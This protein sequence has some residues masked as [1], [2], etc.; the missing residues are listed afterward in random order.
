MTKTAAII[1]AALSVFA[2][3]YSA[4]LPEAQTEAPVEA[5]SFPW[6]AETCTEKLEIEC[7]IEVERTVRACSKAFETAGADVIADIKCAKDL[8]G[9]KKFCW[10]CICSEAKKKGWHVIGC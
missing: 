10:P 9:D 3:F 2:A 1:A 4:T 5:E 7:A 6:N 8:L